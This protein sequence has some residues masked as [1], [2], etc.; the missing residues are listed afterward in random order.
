VKHS[1]PSSMVNVA[2]VDLDPFG[3]DPFFDDSRILG[4]D[5]SA[6]IRK[7]YLR[8][9][10]LYFRG[11]QNAE[12]IEPLLSAFVSHGTMV[13]DCVRHLRIYLR[14]ENFDDDLDRYLAGVPSVFESSE[15]EIAY[16]ERQLYNMYSKRLRP[17]QDLPF[18]ASKIKLEICIFHSLDERVFLCPGTKFRHETRMYNLL[19]A[20]K[21]TYFLARAGAEVTVR[22]ENFFTGAGSDMTWALEANSEAW[23]GVSRRIHSN[24]VTNVAHT[25]KAQR[26][27]IRT[28]R[29]RH[30][31]LV[32]SVDRKDQSCMRS[33]TPAGISDEQELEARTLRWHFLR[34]SLHSMQRS[35][36]VRNYRRFWHS[37]KLHLRLRRQRQWWQRLLGIGS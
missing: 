29:T 14:C 35:I 15:E 26:S 34:V 19:E 16:G 6:E 37:H 9:T 17:L 27:S 4:P 10:P 11:A 2:P 7:F 23:K 22:C 13:R 30:I 31:T 25:I 3:K 5:I 12:D 28:A 1:H 20:V 33:A 36:H 21:P 24:E 18:E 32:A 8:K